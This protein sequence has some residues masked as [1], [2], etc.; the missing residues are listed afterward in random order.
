MHIICLQ[1]LHKFQN[2]YMFW[3]QGAILR[4]CQ[5]QRSTNYAPLYLTLTLNSC[6][7]GPLF[8]LLLS[9]P[10]MDAVFE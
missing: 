7:D 10:R 4:K 2:S 8:P 5:I 1:T 9:H 3:H 6:V